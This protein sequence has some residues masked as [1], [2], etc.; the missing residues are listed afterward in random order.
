[1]LIEK[2]YEAQKIQNLKIYERFKSMNKFMLTKLKKKHYKNPK[3]RKKERNKSENIK[4]HSLYDI[5]FMQ[6]G[7]SMANVAVLA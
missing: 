3:K 6:K 2:A 7:F 5:D 1:M 4:A